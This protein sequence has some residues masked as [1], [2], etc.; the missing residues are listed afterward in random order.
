MN[1]E[2]TTV[3]DANQQANV[4]RIYF[5]L[6]YV[7][8]KNRLNKKGASWRIYGKLDLKDLSSYLTQIYVQ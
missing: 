3:K 1:R 2:I 6:H 8:V 5:N 4:R 7:V